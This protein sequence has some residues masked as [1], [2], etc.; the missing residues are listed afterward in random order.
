MELT[1]S[2]VEEELSLARN[3][4][5]DRRRVFHDE[6]TEVS[7]S[8]RGPQLGEA[9]VQQV[10]ARVSA[11][12][13]ALVVVG[14]GH[15]DLAVG[16][17]EQHVTGM[18]PAALQVDGERRGAAL[19]GHAGKDHGVALMPLQETNVTTYCVEIERTCV[20]TAAVRKCDTFEQNIRFLGF[21]TFER[22]FLSNVFKE[23]ILLSPVCMLE[24]S[25]QRFHIW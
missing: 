18:Q 22:L 7:V 19:F 8:V 1:R 4:F 20:T 10:A 12:S 25:V 5:V 2:D 17:H 3:G 13:D 23:R 24:Y 15:G 14:V 21:D 11:D 9:H 6:L 16:V